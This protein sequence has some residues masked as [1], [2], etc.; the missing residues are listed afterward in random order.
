MTYDPREHVGQ[1]PNSFDPRNN[2]F[3]APYDPRMS[4][5]PSTS[6]DPR[7]IPSNPSHTDPRFNPSL[8][9]SQPSVPHISR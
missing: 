2:Q 3:S 8:I 4:L 5:N 1:P 9:K 7:M 6:L